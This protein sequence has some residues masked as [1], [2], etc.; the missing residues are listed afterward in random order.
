MMLHHGLA[1]KQ[2]DRTGAQSLDY[3]Q[4]GPGNPRVNRVAKRA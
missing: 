3:A 1:D 4:H 2:A